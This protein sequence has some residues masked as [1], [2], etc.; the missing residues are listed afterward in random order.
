MGLAT[1]MGATALAGCASPTATAVPTATPDIAATVA[2]A[3]EAALT[4]TT[5]APT[6]DIQA[7]VIAGVQATVRALPTIP[8]SPT[9]SSTPTLT[10]SPTRGL[11]AAP[12]LTELVA[13]VRP[14]VVRVETNLG[15]GT[16]VIFQ[17]DPGDRSALVLTNFHVIDGASQVRITVNDSVVFDGTLLGV[18]Q[19]R[20]LAVLRICC[21]ADF[22][23]L[24]FGDVSQVEVGSEVIVVG[25]ALGIEGQATVTRGI[26]SAIRDDEDADRQVIQTDAPI[27]PGNSGGPLLSLSGE[28]LGINTFAIRSSGSGVPVEG[29]G[30][31]VSQ[32]TIESVLPSL[33]MGGAVALPTSVPLP[34]LPGGLYQNARFSY[35]IQVPPGWNLDAS[36]E[37]FVQIWDQRTGALVLIIVEEIDPVRYPALDSYLADWEPAALEGW[38]DFRIVAER[39][40]GAAQTV[41][42]QEFLL[43]FVLQGVPHNAVDHWYV[44][45]EYLI[46]VLAIGAVPV[47]DLERYSDVLDSL[48]LSLYSFEPLG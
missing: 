41:Q 29:F 2:A 48:E 20:D 26:V 16:G 9:P 19:L 7:T 36:F 45:S 24:P 42:A 11:M 46:Q 10:P 25:Y 13:Q 35:S 31:A 4:R 1:M 44:R 39:R 23:P 21:S 3:V 22:M 28:V 5:P 33:V 32:V 34:G 37:E 12:R 18:D 40:I 30:F 38:T 17:T 27:N 47:W 6:P 43:T 14:S 15:S 8:P